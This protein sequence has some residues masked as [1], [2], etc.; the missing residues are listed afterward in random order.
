MRVSED[1]LIELAER[2]LHC[3][4]DSASRETLRKHLDLGDIEA[5]RAGF[6]FP[7][8]FGTAGLRGEVGPGPGRVNLETIAQVSWA[9]GQYLSGRS[10][11]SSSLVVM[12][13][14]ARPDSQR[15]AEQAARVLSGCGVRVQLT[16]EPQPTPLIAFA[17]R[18]LRASAGVVVTASHNPRPDNGYKLYDDQGVQIVSPW[19]TEITRYMASFP[20]TSEIPLNEANITELSTAVIERYFSYVDQVSRRWVPEIDASQVHKLAYTPLHGVGFASISRATADLPVELLA[21]PSQVDADGSFPT[22]MFPNPEEPGALDLLLEYAKT[23]GAS[24]G[25]ANDP[26]ADRFALCLPLES[27]CLSPVGVDDSGDV[28]LTR[29]SGDALGL[30]LADLCLKQASDHHACIVSTV[31]STPA[32][33]ALVAR[34]GGQ[35]KRT[36]TGFKWL[37]RAALEEENFVFAYEEALG[38]CLAGPPGSTGVMDKDGISALTTVARLLSSCGGGAALAGRLLELYREFGLWGSFGHSRRFVGHDAALE[39]KLLL[40]RLRAQPLSELVGMRVTAVTDYACGA[41]SRPWYLGAQDLLQLDLSA[42][43]VQAG[44]PTHSRVLIRPS[45]TEPKVK[46]YVHLRSTMQQNAEYAALSKR[47]AEMAAEIAA[48]LFDQCS[49]PV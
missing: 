6:E 27:A 13:F 41:E 45:G 29:L 5:L 47:Q 22:L 16:S 44:E 39:M 46:V 24:V 19:D 49:G 36:L 25:A 11:S 2:W 18:D 31:V 26:D 8:A 14:D 30:L 37:C 33:E 21:V 35:L 23:Q 20:G 43:D 42:T 1:E 28:K 4:A 17:V 7:L 48:A 3:E 9:L 10:P 40:E 34:R 32:L 15:F 38:Y 12:G